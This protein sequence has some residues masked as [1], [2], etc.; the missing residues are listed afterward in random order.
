[1]ELR[2]YKN[3]EVHIFSPDPDEI[4]DIMEKIVHFDKI[5]QD[6]KNGEE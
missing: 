3:D 2:I 5:I 4:L 1:M 6:L